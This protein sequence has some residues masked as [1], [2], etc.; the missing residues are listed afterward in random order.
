MRARWG[1]LAAALL[2]GSA[3]AAPLTAPFGFPP[4]VFQNRAALDASAVVAYTPRGA[5]FPLDTWL[6]TATALGVTNTG[7]ITFAWWENG[8][9]VNTNPTTIVNGGIF[10]SSLT[11]HCETDGTHAAPGL[12][13]SFDASPNKAQFNMNNSTGL[14]N[15][16]DKMEVAGVPATT[17]FIPGTWN[18]YIVSVDTVNGNCAVV[19]NGVNA[20]PGT[21]SCPLTFATF[22]GF[23]DLN[24][25]GG[26]HVFNGASPA[27]TGWLSEVW[28]G[29]ESLV[30]TGLGAPFADCVTANT[31]PPSK[32]AGFVSGGKPV[33]FGATCTNPTGR[34][35]EVCLTG[36]GTA[37]ATNLG[38]A[39]TAF[40]Q[41]VNLSYGQKFGMQKAPFGPAG[42]PANQP[43]LKWPPQWNSS[44]T[45]TSLTTNAGGNP[46]A[47]GDFLIIVANIV[48]SSGTTNHSPTCP[49]GGASTWTAITAADD[50]LGSTNGL[51][52]Y[53]VAGSGE[54]GADTVSWT[55]ANTR[56][57][58]WMLLDYVGVGSVGATN[59]NVGLVSVSGTS[60][61]T[62]STTTVAAGSTLVSIFTNWDAGSATTWTV[63]GSPDELRYAVPKS[64][65]YGQ[66]IVTDAY[67]VASGANTQK[68][69]TMGTN[70]D[71]GIGFTLE[72][73]HP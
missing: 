15:T 53:A 5:F 9:N 42:V 50:P 62:P 22:T 10:L 48:D 14:S 64:A 21:F 57:T 52:C 40:S 72:L 11:T 37:M 35:P 56:T 51:V 38:S 2:C 54:T 13:F 63:P 45:G 44:A 69:V 1:W 3:V 34:Q 58:A 28:I 67:N 61:K 33:G 41:N 36:D 8:T 19:M 4:G 68:T 46:I 39:S 12:C 26:F 32:I 66:I 18:E 16:T 60:I 20:V 71:G 47:T 29:E 70:N 55:T 59:S 30:C 49:T 31:I 24:N 43:T 65:S 7:K 73:K 27:A 23:P 6:G 25:S 17:P